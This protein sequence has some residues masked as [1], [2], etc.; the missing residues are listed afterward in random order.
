MQLLLAAMLLA[1]Q[2]APGAAAAPGAPAAPDAA[3]GAGEPALTAHQATSLRCGVA[4]AIGARLQAGGTAPA[5]WPPLEVRG[6]EFFARVMARLMD[7][8]G[9]SRD[10]L[11]AMALRETG[12]LRDPAALAAVMPACLPLL[13]AAGL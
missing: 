10:T 5:G 8:T 1:A 3:P 9:A 12:A 11:A 2:P 7:D 6:K 13:D 4:F